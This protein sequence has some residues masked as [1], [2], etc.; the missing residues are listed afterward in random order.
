[1]T[2]IDTDYNAY[3]YTTY[4][5]AMVALAAAFGWSALRLMSARRKLDEAER[6]EKIG[7]GSAEP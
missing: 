7:D 5:I 6:V 3:V 2:P 4:A 1:M